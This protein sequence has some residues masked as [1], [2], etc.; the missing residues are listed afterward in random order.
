MKQLLVIILLFATLPVTAQVLN[1]TSVQHE[2][3]WLDEYRFPPFVTYKQVQDSI[4]SYTSQI[5]ANK[6]NTTAGILPTGISYHNITGFGKAKLKDPGTSA[7]EKDYQ[8]S[9]LSFITRATTGLDVFWNMKIEVRQNGR[10]VFSKEITHQV[11]YFADAP[12]WFTE[13]SFISTFCVFFDELVEKSSPL[14]YKYT[15]G[16]GF[17]SDSLL[18][19]RSVVWD[20]AR[21][22]ELFGFATPA[23]GPYVTTDA[24]KVD[25]ATIRKSTKLG[26]DTYFGVT[27]DLLNYSKKGAVIGFDQFK[28]FD[29][30]VTKFCKLDLVNDIDTMHS[31]FAIGVQTREARR[32]VAGV[33]FGSSNSLTP[34]TLYYNRDVAGTIFTGLTAWEFSI[35]GYKN[36]GTF[37]KGF[38]TDGVNEFLFEF[39]Q[40]AG[41]NFEVVV[42]D[43][44]GEY[45]G[46]L[47]FRLSKTQLLLR[48]D[49]S[50]YTKNAIAVLYA[51]YLSVKNVSPS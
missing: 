48:N 19:A 38:L 4:I 6:F 46:S 10:S 16:T 27:D 39:V 45:F 34:Q 15:V 51:I 49:V 17:D 43:S 37:Y 25:T 28:V 26:T 50:I 21:N 44:K 18:R 7:S 40:H 35:S 42:K 41:Y 3:R 9:V 23:F 29:R 12:Q 33:L 36:D 32:T 22:R 24:G 20:V 5:L 14:A 2:I 30:S 8:A 13:E 31:F 11:L 1:L 47:I